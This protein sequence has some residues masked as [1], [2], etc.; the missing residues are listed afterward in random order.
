MMSTEHGMQRI[1][2]CRMSALVCIVD[3]GNDVMHF[4]DEAGRGRE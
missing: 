3:M 2:E 1:I 4:V